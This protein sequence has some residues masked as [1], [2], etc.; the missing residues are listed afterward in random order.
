MILVARRFR[1]Y[2]TIPLAVAQHRKKRKEKKKEGSSHVQKGTGRWS[3][4]ALSQP[5]PVKTN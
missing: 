5:V 4:L 1:Q 2:D 3:A